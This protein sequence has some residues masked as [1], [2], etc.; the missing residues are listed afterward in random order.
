MLSLCTQP[1]NGLCETPLFS[2]DLLTQTLLILPLSFFWFT[3]LQK[4]KEPTKFKQQQSG[5]AV[6]SAAVFRLNGR[7][8]LAA[9]GGFVGKSFRLRFVRFLECVC[10]AFCFDFWVA[11]LISCM[12]HAKRQSGMGIGYEKQLLVLDRKIQR[13]T[14]EIRQ[15]RISLVRTQK[16]LLFVAFSAG[17]G[18]FAWLFLTQRMR[19]VP[20]PFRMAGI[21]AF[22][23][24]VA[25]V[26][27][28]LHGA[29]LW[30]IRRQEV[31]LGRLKVARKRTVEE[32]KRKSDYYRTRT[33]IERFDAASDDEEEHNKSENQGF[34]NTC[35]VPAV[36]SRVQAPE[37]RVQ[38]ATSSS[39]VSVPPTRSWLDKIVDGILGEEPAHYRYALIC[40]GCH[41]HNGLC[42]FEE[43]PQK[44]F[45]C[46]KCGLLNV[47]AAAAAHFNA[48][49]PT[50]HEGEFSSTSEAPS[51]LFLHEATTQETVSIETQ[52]SAFLAEEVCEVSSQ[53]QASTHEISE[54]SKPVSP[55]AAP[56]VNRKR[57]SKKK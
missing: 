3:C 8:F 30:S 46:F 24:A 14:Q 33:L 56:I 54:A 53:S 28:V 23:A 48:S 39:D 57:R 37:S 32:F 1:L 44:R 11:K 26:R 40:R 34:K 43:V 31:Q 49:S 25:A 7:P 45:V 12:H 35:N 4:I 6:R 38:S 29:F 27:R 22:S 5:A 15:R 52:D 9:F 51:P 19:R 16:A 41:V 18:V 2:L 36:E 20:W 17:V 10:V 55:M 21:A 47:P 42:F 13:I 50:S